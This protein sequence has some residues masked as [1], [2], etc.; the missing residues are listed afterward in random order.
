MLCAWPRPPAWPLPRRPRAQHGPLPRSA[1]ASSLQP[2]YGPL[3]RRAPA[4]A[5]SAANVTIASRQLHTR[6]AGALS[7]PFLKPRFGHRHRSY[8][9]C[10]STCTFHKGENRRPAR[11]AA[12]PRGLARVTAGRHRSRRLSHR[13]QHRADFRSLPHL[14]APG[15]VHGTAATQQTTKITD[16]V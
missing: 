4:R 7:T 16:S 2:L 15:L 5:P 8:A 6:A 9:I 3:P 12:H 11:R 14:L 1:L 10:M 13:T